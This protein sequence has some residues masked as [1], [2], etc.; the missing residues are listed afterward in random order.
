M[1]GRRPEQ[2]WVWTG[3][4]RNPLQGSHQ[5]SPNMKA[6]AGLDRRGQ[7]QS[8]VGGRTGGARDCC[9]WAEGQAW[10]LGRQV[11]HSCSLAK[12]PPP[13]GLR[14]KTHRAK[15]SAC[16]RVLVQV[17]LPGGLEASSFVFSCPQVPAVLPQT[18]PGVRVT[19]SAAAQQRKAMSWPAS[20]DD[21]PL[22]DRTLPPAQ[23]R[24]RSVRA[25]AAWPETATVGARVVDWTS[26]AAGRGSR[27]LTT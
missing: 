23:K 25:V 11:G 17:L 21:P 14:A 19:A 12:D 8:C 22:P 13:W 10:G 3:L 27:N 20:Q 9:S 6:A 26:T 2:R 24:P 4:D 15:A 16:W 18:V 7:F 1:T 5:N